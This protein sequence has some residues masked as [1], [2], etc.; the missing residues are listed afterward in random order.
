MHHDSITGTS[1]KHVVVDYAN[2]LHAAFETALRVLSG[3][4][5]SRLGVLWQHQVM[6]QPI[7]SLSG[8]HHAVDEVR[9]RL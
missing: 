6:L 1:K 9:W 4:L 8:A 2:R 5:A 7:K 3:A